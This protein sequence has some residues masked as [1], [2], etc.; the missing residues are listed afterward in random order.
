[1]NQLVCFIAA[2]F[3]IAE[4]TSCIPVVFENPFLPPQEC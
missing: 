4:L 2:G 1:M 3:L